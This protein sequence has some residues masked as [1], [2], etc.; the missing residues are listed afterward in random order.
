MRQNWLF[1]LVGAFACVVPSRGQI[2]ATLYFKHQQFS[3]FDL[4]TLNVSY[5]SFLEEGVIHIYIF[6][7]FAYMQIWNDAD[8]LQ[9]R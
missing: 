8:Y 6:S 9:N 2:S 1:A 5:M 4:N 7:K 3:Y